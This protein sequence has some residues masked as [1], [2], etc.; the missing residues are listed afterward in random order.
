MLASYATTFLLW[1]LFTIPLCLFSSPPLRVSVFSESNGAGLE[2]DRT[3]LADAL[4]G[5][6]HIVEEKETFKT[7]PQNGVIADIHIYFEKIDARCLPSARLNWFIPNPEFYTQD[8]ALLDKIDLVLC[9]TREAERIFQGL[10]KATFFLGFTS[11]D[12][13]D[14][15]VDKNFGCFLHLAGASR[16]KNTP[17]VIDF[18]KGN[19]YLPPLLLIHHG[20]KLL[21][22]QYNIRWISSRVPEDSLKYIQNY[23]GIHLCPSIAEGYG[24]YIMEAMSTGAVVITTD[25]PPMNEFISDK[26]LLVPYSHSSSHTLGTAY[27]PTTQQLADVVYNCLNLSPEECKKIGETNR[28]TF[29]QKKR[30]FHENLKRL[31]QTQ[32]N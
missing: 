5:L 8:L 14:P 6:G 4:K 28:Q 19:L 23:H 31:F 26:R 16:T 24:H 15:S 9:R 17:L 3:I 25:A 11:L 18:W 27:F 20:A 7:D 22:E 12:R 32:V 2:R 13:Y 1:L 30:E 21:T 10:N 29:L